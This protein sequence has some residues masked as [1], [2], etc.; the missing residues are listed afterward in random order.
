[1]IEKKNTELHD[2]YRENEN[3]IKNLPNDFNVSPA[4]PVSNDSYKGNDLGKDYKKGKKPFARIS[5]NTLTDMS[6][7]FEIMNKEMQS[8]DFFTRLIAVNLAIEEDKSYDFDVNFAKK[9]KAFLPWEDYFYNGKSKFQIFSGKNVPEWLEVSNKSIVFLLYLVK[10][11]NWINIFIT[12]NS[13]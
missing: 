5:N 8:N 4:N 11:S 7:T 1:M 13:S 9:M 6:D 12:K 3:L 2:I 10:L